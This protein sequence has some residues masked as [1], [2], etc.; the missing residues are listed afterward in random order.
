M[1]ERELF[2]YYDYLAHE[3]KSANRCCLFPFVMLF[4]YFCIVALC[5]ALI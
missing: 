3:R 4:I 5:L 2:E 1:N